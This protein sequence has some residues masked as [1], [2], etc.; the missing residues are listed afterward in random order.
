MGRDMEIPMNLPLD[1]DGFVRRECPHCV[2]QFKW[3]H[4][5]ANAEAEQQPSPALPP[6][7]G[8]WSKN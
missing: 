1:N 4:G 2:S 8:W 6:Q 5:P 3:H 7:R